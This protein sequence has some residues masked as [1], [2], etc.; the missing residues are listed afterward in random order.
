MFAK[1]AEISGTL[2]DS[3]SQSARIQM[4]KPE[5]RLRVAAA[6]MDKDRNIFWRKFCGETSVKP[7]VKAH[8]I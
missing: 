4:R 7:S 1:S 8:L 2:A 5:G 3:V 6:S